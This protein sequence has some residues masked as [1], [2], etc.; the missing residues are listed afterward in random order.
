VIVIPYVDF[1]ALF[2]SSAVVANDGHL[3]FEGFDETFRPFTNWEFAAVTGVTMDLAGSNDAAAFV[4]EW[5]WW[6]SDPGAANGNPRWEIVRAD[7]G[8]GATRSGRVTLRLTAHGVTLLP[9]QEA[10]VM[11]ALLRDVHLYAWRISAS[12]VYWA[13]LHRCAFAPASFP[14]TVS[15]TIT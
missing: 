8:G 6:L 9:S 11:S 4:D 1:R 14:P 5:H 13:D 12:D 15:V 10:D 2:T 3:T 7:P